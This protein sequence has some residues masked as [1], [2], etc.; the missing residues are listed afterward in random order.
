[1][2]RVR[3]TLAETMREVGVI[4]EAAV[5]SETEMS[6]VKL[7]ASRTSTSDEPRSVSDRK[8]TTLHDRDH[9]RRSSDSGNRQGQSLD[10]EGI[11]QVFETRT[12]FEW[13]MTEIDPCR[14]RV[15]PVLVPGD[16]DVEVLVL[17]ERGLF[18]A[19]EVTEVDVW[20]GG[21]FGC[22]HNVTEF[23]EGCRIHGPTV[24]FRCDAGIRPCRIDDPH[25][26]D[27][28]Q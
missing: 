26:N 19:V 4:D 7:A 12:L 15:V 18:E 5:A 24:G 11:R 27:A 28:Q 3:S 20:A 2:S 6:A 25:E 17:G 14:R 1:M 13:E 8:V 21:M 9:R 10:G 22:L 16:R 23:G